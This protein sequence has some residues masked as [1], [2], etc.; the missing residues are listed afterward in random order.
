MITYM[1]EG[2]FGRM[3]TSGWADPALCAGCVEPNTAFY[4]AANTPYLLVPALMIA[5]MWRPLPFGVAQPAS[6]DPTITVDLRQEPSA[7]D[8]SV[9]DNDGDQRITS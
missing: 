7:V 1:A 8:M 9:D 4:L 5:R 2:I 6:Q 3:A